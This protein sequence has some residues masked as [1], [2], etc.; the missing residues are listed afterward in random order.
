MNAQ[1]KINDEFDT[2][3][4]ASEGRFI[5]Q[6]DDA[7]GFMRSTSYKNEKGFVRACKKMINEKSIV[8]GWYSDGSPNKNFKL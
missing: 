2:T 1:I 7:R 8:R 4:T 6:W 3:F 5:K